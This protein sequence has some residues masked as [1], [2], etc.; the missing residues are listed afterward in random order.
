MLKEDSVRVTTFHGLCTWAAHKAGLEIP[1][2]D[3]SEQL[4]DN[5]YPSMLA[6]SAELRWDIRFDAIIVDEGQDFQSHWWVAVDALLSPGTESSLYVFFDSNQGVYG[7]VPSLPRD[8]SLLPIRLTRNLRNTKA[9]HDTAAVFYEGFAV[10]AIGPQGTAPEW[11]VEERDRIPSAVRQIVTGLVRHEKV[12]LE[13]IAVLTSSRR[14]LNELIDNGCLGSYPVCES[15]GCKGDPA[16]TVDTILRFKGLESPVV[17]LVVVEAL[18]D[19]LAYVALSRAR[20][21]LTIIGTD[22]LLSN[23]RC[24]IGS[25]R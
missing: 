15:G 22:K 3:S 23:L 19:E 18:T 13:S 21:L 12:P 14:V 4:F 17:V 1:E 10:Q 5:I 24:G 20:S 11:L 7:S 16:L 2:G 25:Q 9:I 6:D 8:A